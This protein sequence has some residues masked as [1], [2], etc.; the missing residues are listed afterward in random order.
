V[1]SEEKFEFVREQMLT[2]WRKHQMLDMECPYCLAMVPK[3]QPV[4]CG[5]MQRAVEVIIEWKLLQEK[6]EFAN[7]VLEQSK[8]VQ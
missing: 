8:L 4:C 7:R 2:V 6:I 1:T 5:T 3:G